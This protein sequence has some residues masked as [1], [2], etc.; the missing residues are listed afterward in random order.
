MTISS[1]LE[2]LALKMD[3]WTDFLLPSAVNESKQIVNSKIFSSI[4]L[5]VSI[6]FLFIAISLFSFSLNSNG[7][8]GQRGF[9]FFSGIMDIGLILVI[10][11][12]LYQNMSFERSNGSLELIS[13]T[14]VTPT[15]FVL[16]KWQSGLLQSLIFG[17]IIFPGLIFSYFFNAISISAI[18]IGIF[19]TIIF[20]QFAIILSILLCS[21]SKSK[22]IRLGLQLIAN[23][24]NIY[25]LY[26]V[27]KFKENISNNEGN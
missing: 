23:F 19:S 9:I 10:P 6:C 18:L 21:L 14:S 15:K 8:S 4:F 12:I 16:G 22:S 5:S 3:D 26:M 17:S 13:I 24:I 1:T 7:I 11:A 27:I 2:Y 20:S 25:I